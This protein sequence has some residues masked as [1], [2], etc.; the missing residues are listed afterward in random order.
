MCVVLLLAKPPRPRISAGGYEPKLMVSFSLS[1]VISYYSSM[2]NRQPT[3]H[4][5]AFFNYYL[6]T[7]RACPIPGH[8]A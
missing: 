6:N 2:L 1:T 7:P 3:S 8:R 5:I 4:P